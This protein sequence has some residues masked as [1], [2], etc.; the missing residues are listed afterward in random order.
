M[1]MHVMI[2]ARKEK[3]FFH[4]ARLPDTLYTALWAQST[5]VTAMT[6]RTLCTSELSLEPMQAKPTAI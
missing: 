2:P 1:S 5:A 3:F 4:A 6:A